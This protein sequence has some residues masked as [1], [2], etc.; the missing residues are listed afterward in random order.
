M[1]AG[2]FKGFFDVEQSLWFGVFEK[3]LQ[4]DFSGNA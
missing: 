1:A 3:Y 4:L 2:E